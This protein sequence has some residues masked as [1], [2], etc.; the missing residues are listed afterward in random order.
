MKTVDWW[1]CCLNV[2]ERTIILNTCEGL[3][4]T[5]GVGI[6]IP[7]WNA[8]W[9]ATGYTASIYKEMF[10]ACF[11]LETA[12]VTVDEAPV[13]VVRPDSDHSANWVLYVLFVAT[14]DAAC[15]AGCQQS[16]VPT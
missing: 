10:R 1:Y 9:I 5:A 11:G 6:P 7:V 4:L 3:V 16:R 13:D 15:L 12:T 2:R 14:P 8:F